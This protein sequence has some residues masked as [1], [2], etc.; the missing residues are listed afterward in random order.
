MHYRQLG[1]TDLKVSEV[2]LGTMTWGTQNTQEEAFEQMDYALDAGVNFFDC[3]EMYPTPYSEETH[4][5]TEEIIGNWFAARGTRDKVIL[6][7]KALGPGERFKEVRGGPRFNR[8]Q[9]EQAVDASLRRLQTDRIDLYQLHWPER[10]TNRF[11]KLGFEQPG[12]EGDWTPF[13]ETL[14][15][16]QD[17]VDKGKIRHIGLSND[18]AWGTM[19]MLTHAEAGKGPRVMSVQNPYSLLN[20]SFEAGLSEVAIR[21]Q[22]GLLAYAPLAAGTLTGKYL[23]GAKPADARLILYP[24]NSR[25]WKEQGIKAIEA[26]VDLAKRHGLD[27]AQMAIQFVLSRPFTT[28]AIIGATK[29]W[30]LKNN[31]AAKDLRLSDDVLQELEAIHTLYTYPCP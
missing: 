21:E 30:H 25:Y 2:C 31:I 18:T 28:S 4:G 16:L 26:Y 7:T 15:A 1:R 24:Q 20:R 11:G 3:A 14:G 10:S 19:R 8:A 12:D 29:M 5:G 6:A 27:A 17:L 9:L 22:C 23:H 13:E